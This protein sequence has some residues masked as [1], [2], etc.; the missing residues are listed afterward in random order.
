MYATAAYVL[1][2]SVILKNDN[3]EGR[4]IDDEEKGGKRGKGRIYTSL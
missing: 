1:A 2:S 3:F 4:K